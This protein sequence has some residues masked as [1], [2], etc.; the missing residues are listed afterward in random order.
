MLGFISGTIAQRILVEPKVTASALMSNR[1]GPAT[2]ASAF[3]L[4]FPTLIDGVVNPVGAITTNWFCDLGLATTVFDDTGS[5]YLYVQS[6]GNGPSPG[7]G[8]TSIVQF[9]QALVGTVRT[10]DALFPGT[11]L[12][13]PLGD[14]NTGEAG[15][16]G[17]FLFSNVTSGSGSADD[18]VLN[19]GT[20]ADGV[21]GQTYRDQVTGLT[22]TI[23]PRG[24]STSQ[25]GPFLAYPTGSNATFRIN[26]SR[27]FVTDANLPVSAFAGLE[28]TVTNTS[29]VI[30]GDTA[31]ID[32]FNKSG[33][34]PSIG[35]VYY[36]SYTFQKQDY[37]T[38]FYTKMSAIENAYGAISP[39]NPVSLASFLAIINGAI[40]V[41]IK[42]VPRAEDEPQADL[43]TYVSAIE[44]L[45][46]VL[47]GNTRP[48]I[49]TPL[50]GDS[51]DLYLVLRRSNAIQ[52]SIRY[53]S[54]RT[55]IIGMAAGSLPRDAITLA[56]TLSDTRMRLVYPDILTVSIQ[57]AV[58]NTTESLIDGPM[59]A[60][61]LVGS[62]VSANVD[63]ATP[64]TGRRLVGYTQLARK[65]DAVEMNQVAQKGVTMFEERPPFLRCRH[66]LTTDMTNILTKLPTIVLIADE[67]QRQART[68]LEVFIGIKFLPGILSQIEGRLSM[69]LN[70]LQ[71]QNIISAYTGVAANVAPDDPTVAE[72]EAFYQPVFPLL[73]LILTFHLRS[74]L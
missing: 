57:D 19:N 56:E 52:S 36:V 12:N 48:D 1:D 55:S 34:E 64:W 9:L 66:G 37:T 47:P 58:G 29:G 5:E 65:L 13:I 18:S 31:I 46:G 23:L 68:V 39:D 30:A 20:G 62:V 67:V 41:G 44:E 74:S 45:E 60:A 16:D 25:T 26:V 43:P 15:L 35:D 51:T 70:A 11:G 17:F 33:T 14:G 49:I 22:L 72:I 54:E 73:Y 7:A 69:M 53:R 6:L 8:T 27:T 63:V 42:Q 40:V 3:V 32:T 71:K 50:R 38:A 24:W 2:F 61:G 10:D 21:V 59:L 28:T 4:A